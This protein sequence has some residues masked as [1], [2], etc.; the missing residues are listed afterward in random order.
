MINSLAKL[1]RT[2]RAFGE[3]F[4]RA[5]GIHCATHQIRVILICCVVITSLLYPALALYSTTTQVQYLSRLRILTSFSQDQQSL[6]TPDLVELWAGHDTVTQSTSA[7]LLCSIERTLRVERILIR[8][9]GADD[10][11]DY[12]IL[13]SALALEQTIQEMLTSNKVPCVTVGQKCLALTPLAFW[14]H[15]AKRVSG[16]PNIL[17]TLNSRQNITYS[18]IT[19][20]PAMV[21]AGREAD[22]VFEPYFD[23]AKFLSLTFFLLEDNCVSNV[24]HNAWLDIVKKSL[25]RVPALSY[26]QS[27]RSV[28]APQL[29]SLQFQPKEFNSISLLTYSAYIII[30][31]YIAW[32]VRSMEASM[33][34]P[35]GLAVTGLVEI[36]ASTV[37]SLSVCALVGFKVTLVPWELLPL[38]L[39][40]VGAE[41]MI[42]LAEA[43]VK[44][45]VT[46]PVKQRLAEGL[47][48]AGTSNT[49]KLIVY[50]TVLG[51]IAGFSTGAIQ[52]FCAFA[53]VVLVAHW[54]L[55]HVFFVT[56]LSI[57]IQRL[58][59]EDLIRQDPSSAPTIS[60][61]K[62]KKAIRANTF[63]Q[64]AWVKLQG[65]LHGRASKNLSLVLL[66]AVTAVLYYTT[67][68]A[69]SDLYAGHV[70]APRTSERAN[71][72]H[73]LITAQQPWNILNP[74]RATHLHLS[75]QPPTLL[76]F[77]P[78]TKAEKT[79]ERKSGP[80][81]LSS[82]AILIT[83]DLAKIILLPIAVTTGLLYLLLL[84]LLKD[85]ELLEAQR[86][87]A[88]EDSTA[89]S[90]KES[91]ASMYTFSTIPRGTMTD[92]DLIAVNQDG[93]VI[94]STS[95]QGEISIWQKATHGYERV[96]TS[97]LTSTL[98][99]GSSAGYLITAVTVDT[100]GEFVAFGT[101]C[102]L[103]AA[104][105]LGAS[106]GSPSSILKE[107]LQPSPVTEL[108][109]VGSNRSATLV[110]VASQ[111][112]GYVSRWQ[113]QKSLNHEPVIP[114]S[115]VL[116]IGS[117]LLRFGPG[118]SYVVGF[119]LADG[120]F[121]LE[122]L[123]GTDVILLHDEP[124]VAGTPHD[125]VSQLHACKTYFEGGERIVLA[126][127]TE[128]GVVSLWDGQSGECI[129]V[130]EDR[131]GKVSSLRVSHIF[132][133]TC[134]FCGELPLESFSLAFAVDSIVVF[135]KAYMQSQTR[136]CTCSHY[137]P[138]PSV[139]RESTTTTAGGGRLSRSGSVTNSPL[140]GPVRLRTPVPDSTSLFPVSGHGVHSRRASDNGSVLRS[141]VSL[142]LPIPPAFEFLDSVPSPV[143][144]TGRVS[145]G[146]ATLP[147]SFWR[148]LFLRKELETSCGRGG[149]GSLGDT[150]LVGLRR[151]SRMGSGSGGGSASANVGASTPV[152]VLGGAN[153]GH[154]LS[155]AA[156]GRWEVWLYDPN[157][158][159]LQQS[160]LASLLRLPPSPDE[161]SVGSRPPSRRTSLSSIA[162]AKERDSSSAHVPRLP[163]TRASPV[164]GGNK[165]YVGFGNTIGIIESASAVS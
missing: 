97:E 75:I 158:V 16:D 122:K 98:S 10:V 81:L 100:A 67:Y 132:C 29:I 134:H 112:P 24:G 126:S 131:Y 143:Y 136:R 30:L 113:V 92:T 124:F 127:S 28:P 123:D 117:T 84:Y 147:S 19:L 55:A 149:W 153:A 11:L 5:F 141:S 139:I 49:L 44:T 104:W 161:V 109:F 20:S 156:L 34:S 85:A 150:K 165:I 80:L 2:I 6:Y 99:S 52:Q 13:R 74:S 35:I 91:L 157:S 71:L 148:N 42:S 163:F 39:F 78:N 135:F 88:E 120:T 31:A 45:P 33:H 27:S 26:D 106:D 133:E 94:V 57:D 72:S 137:Q 108:T 79:H 96:D 25:T 60:P 119:L 14:N 21:F 101:R 51:V 15:D 140:L 46:L 128:A 47:S 125:P 114:R 93:R 159:S 9:F 36:I 12:P 162:S 152:P 58:E 32:S 23:K 116:I 40:F 17:H 77:H 111:K 145:A 155:S 121:C 48:K 110:L 118:G 102:G 62:E 59:L 73:H 41:N 18:G 37:T 87:R 61:T 65:L 105:S 38:I 82:K 154:S 68:P 63:Q 142:S 66:L 151:R 22:E 90:Q 1:S 138:R 43:V 146:G 64:K 89:T 86:N 144:E 107:Q 164:V 53:I 95:V 56:V 160:T 3:R 54:F 70:P 8:N 115:N 83:Y 76:S 129:T 130:L 4:F 69:T 103:V 7:S 50:N